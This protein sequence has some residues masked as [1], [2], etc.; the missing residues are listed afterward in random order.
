MR[1][2]KHKGEPK[3]LA[4]VGKLQ[5][6]QVFEI[7]DW[8]WGALKDRPDYELK[9][10]KVSEEQRNMN[11]VTKPLCVDNIFDLRLIAWGDSNLF[12]R[13]QARY[14]LHTLNKIIN[15][16]ETVGC[17]V[18]RSPVYRGLKNDSVDIIVSV[19]RVYEWD[20]LTNDEISSLGV[21]GEVTAKPIRKTKTAKK[22]VVRKRTRKPESINV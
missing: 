22:K 19:A 7:Y 18:Y 3:T 12:K 6:N 1:I 14:S 16:M 20:K 15:A 10:K 21:Y 5:K 8:Y 2:V 4:P 17:K 9:E 11:R 13:L